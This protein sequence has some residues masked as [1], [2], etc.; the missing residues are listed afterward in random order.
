MN[1]RRLLSVIIL[2]IFVLTWAFCKQGKTQNHE[3]LTLPPLGNVSRLEEWKNKVY[4]QYTL[5]ELGESVALIQDLNSGYSLFRGVDFNAPEFPGSLDR[6]I[7][8]M[9][10]DV[11]ERNRLEVQDHPGSISARLFWM[12]T[13]SSIDDLLHLTPGEHGKW[14]YKWLLNPGQPGWQRLDDMGYFNGAYTGAQ[15]FARDVLEMGYGTVHSGRSDIP[16]A[17]FYGNKP[18]GFIFAEMGYDYYESGQFIK[19]F[20]ERPAPAATYG[21]RLVQELRSTLMTKRSA[22]E[23]YQRR[24]NALVL[25]TLKERDT[26]RFLLL[27]QAR[28]QRER[29]LQ[30]EE[31][32][33]REFDDWLRQLKDEV[34]REKNKERSKSTWHRHFRR[35]LTSTHIRRLLPSRRHDLSCHFRLFSRYILIRPPPGNH[36]TPFR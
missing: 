12:S 28:Q 24:F 3:T 6:T 7:P 16:V 33:R 29:E 4:L 14:D 1:S 27:E 25:R 35:S 15:V 20:L 8:A 10:P 34:E 23:E 30:E 19:D 18:A 36:H 2:S 32:R 11:Y 26:K 22:D 21:D 9:L 31:R 17:E 5:P 13:Q